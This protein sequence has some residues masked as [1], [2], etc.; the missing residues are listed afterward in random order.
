MN[1]AIIIRVV[2]KVAASAAQALIQAEK[3][4][5]DA[6]RAVVL[7]M[8]RKAIE[9]GERRAMRDKYNDEQFVA[10]VGQVLDGVKAIIGS[11]NR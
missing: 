11:I 1:T 3:D 5:G 9:R 4:G 8:V 10:G 2:L 7:A 6:R